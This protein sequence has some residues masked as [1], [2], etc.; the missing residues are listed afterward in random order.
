M[1]LFFKCPVSRD[2]V[3][4]SQQAQYQDS[5]TEAAKW[6]SA[7]LILIFIIIYTCAFLT[8]TCQNVFLE[9]VK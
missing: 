1:A 6:K 8:V 4:V 7:T 5:E 3:T 2:S 9:K